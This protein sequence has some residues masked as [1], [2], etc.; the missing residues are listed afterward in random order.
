MLSKGE[1][2]EYRLFYQMFRYR[3]TNHNTTQS[4]S[5]FKIIHLIMNF[6]YFFTIAILL[7][8]FQLNAQ[9]NAAYYRLDRESTNTNARS[10]APPLFNKTVILKSST[11]ISLETREQKFSDEV[12][13]GTTLHFKVVLNVKADGKVV[14]R[15]G[16]AAIGVIKSIR[17]A[18]FNNEAQIT[19]TLKHVQAVDDTLVPLIGDELTIKGV[20]A[21]EGTVILPLQ[22]IMATVANNTE[23]DP[24]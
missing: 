21:G 20:N 17:N 18:S 6:A 9:N 23:I 2:S 22:S 8:N 1:A 12:T 13:V 15:T 5:N 14:V 7:T 10:V 4:F 19:I 16:A 3:S 24:D 11:P